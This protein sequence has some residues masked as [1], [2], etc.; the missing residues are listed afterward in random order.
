M[1]SDAIF[2]HKFLQDRDD[3]FYAKYLEELSA[4]KITQG[5]F[6]AKAGSSPEYVYF[7]MNG[8][9]MNTTTNRYYESG[10][11]LNHDCIVRKT[12]VQHNYIA[13]TD[14]AVFRYDKETFLKICEQ[15][16]DFDED[17]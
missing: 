3:N 2:I 11:I 4:E 17:V 10:Q 1:Y 6:V 14:I 7:I 5:T 9:V 16:P 12:S 13:H 8:I 15:F